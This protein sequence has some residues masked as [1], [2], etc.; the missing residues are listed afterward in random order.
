MENCH[1]S[2]ETHQWTY[3]LESGIGFICKS[4][5]HFAL[6]I[7]SNALDHKYGIFREDILSFK[8]YDLSFCFIIDNT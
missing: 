1:C 6:Y 7:L 2:L 5:F 4:Y 3:D 8:T